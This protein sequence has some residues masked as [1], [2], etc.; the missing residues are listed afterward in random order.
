[1]TTLMP[2]VVLLQ[3]FAETWHIQ[4]SD[5]A[6]NIPRLELAMWKNNITT[7]NKKG[8]ERWH[9]SKR[10]Y[11]GECFLFHES[12]LDKNKRYFTKGGKHRVRLLP[13]ETD[14]CTGALLSITVSPVSLG[15]YVLF[16][17][18]RMNTFMEQFWQMSLSFNP[19]SFGSNSH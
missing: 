6:H 2:S 16:K 8:T 19:I 11:T 13:A 10:D 18:Q 15:L 1:M 7:Q 17:I 5:F 4:H 14:S 9:F 3:W 12:T